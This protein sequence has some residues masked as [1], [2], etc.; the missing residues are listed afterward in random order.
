MPYAPRTHQ[1][2][3]AS[4]PEHVPASSRRDSPSRRWYGSARWKAI[5]RAW[6]SEHPLCV[7]C[8]AMGR[9]VSATVVDHVTPHKEDAGEMWGGAVQSLCKR[10]HDSKTAREDGGF[11]NARRE[12]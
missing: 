3:R 11:G 4:C 10:H 1:P 5:R 12:A 7:R 2:P 6:L 9:T 8:L